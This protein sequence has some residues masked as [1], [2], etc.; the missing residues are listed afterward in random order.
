MPASAGAPL[1]FRAVQAQ[2]SDAVPSVLMLYWSEYGHTRRICERIGSELARRGHASAIAPLREPGIRLGDHDL[3]VIGA[4]IRHGKHDPAV[5]EFILKHREQLESRPSAFF[6]VSLV[7]RKPTR[8]TPQSN[9]YVRAFIERSPWKPDLVG[10][11][12][13]ELDYRRYGAFDRH[14]IRFIM[15][16]TGGPTDLDTKVEF[17][18]WDEVR[19]FAERLAMRAAG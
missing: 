1:T 10:V 6:S 5:L 17:T 3:I 18:D 2:A 14:A 19:R 4:S 13:G 12:A 16:L 7:A 9:P 8:N 15:R 11:F